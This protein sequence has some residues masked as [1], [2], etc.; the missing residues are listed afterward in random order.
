[1]VLLAALVVNESRVDQPIML[2]WQFRSR[3]RSGAYAAR[4]R[5][6]GT[7][8]GFFYFTTLCMQDARFHPAA[9]GIGF[10]PMS[11]VNFAVAMAIPRLSARIPNALLI[12]GGAA[13]TLAGIVWL[14]RAGLGDGPL[15]PWALP[16]ML[17]GAGQGLAFAPLSNAG[18]ARATL[19]PRP[20]W[21]TPP[22][23][24]EWLLASA[25][26]SPCP[27]CRH[28]CR[29]PGCRGRPRQRRPHRQR[30]HA[31]ARPRGRACLH[32]AGRIPPTG[33]VVLRGRPRPP[34]A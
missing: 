27:G 28:E 6:L 26:S 3:E 21:S 16:M 10:L 8:I 1:M 9:A 4:M 11:L 19:T 13:V 7:M 24:S 25:S 23:S 17:V 34:A 22:T 15:S 5:S 12:A 30:C 14:S 29:W 20:A 18:I 32:R 31:R 2:L 33:A